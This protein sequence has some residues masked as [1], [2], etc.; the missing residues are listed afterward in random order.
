MQIIATK[1]ILEYTEQNIET[2]E[3]TFLVKEGETVEA[4]IERMFNNKSIPSWDNKD[5]TLVIKIVKE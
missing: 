2:S 4:L 3:E 5:L 1:Q